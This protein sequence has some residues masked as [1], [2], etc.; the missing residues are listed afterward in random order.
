MRLP[1]MRQERLE[2]GVH[3]GEMF[4]VNLTVIAARRDV[5]LFG[6]SN[7]SREFFNVEHRSIESLTSLGRLFALKHRD[8]VGMS[9]RSRF[10]QLFKLVSR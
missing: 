5:A 9:F 2:A 8:G 4:G 7:L 3:R 6:L 1:D 10:I